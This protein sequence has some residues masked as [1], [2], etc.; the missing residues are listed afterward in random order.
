[1]TILF[2]HHTSD[3]YGASRSLLRLTSR[4]RAEGHKV[5]AILP[6]KGSLCDELDRVGVEVVLL[7]SLA[8][9]NR[10][11][12]GLAG[13]FSLLW[14]LPLSVL[15]IASLI[16]RRDV[17]LVHTN[18]AVILSSPI[19]ARLCGRP[20]VWHVRGFFTEFPG[21]WK[22]HRWIM[23]CLSDAVI[24]VSVAVSR[25]FGEPDGSGRVRVIHNGFPKQEFEGVSQARVS[26][27][28]AAFGLNGGP[29]AGVVGRIKL[30]RKGQE[31][32]I[33]AAARLAERLPKAKFL[34]IGSPFPGNEE[35]LAELERM[36]S[37]Y[38][39]KGRVIYTGDVADIKAAFAALDVTV[40]PTTLP[41]PFGGVVVE[42]M[43]MGRP[44]VA[45]A[46]E[47]A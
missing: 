47:E 41:E 38:G 25:Q 6:G 30:R 21:L 22:I 36:V 34:L 19:A 46:I 18:T 29:V 33:R 28:R 15:C 16:R 42:S 1:M 9:V 17:D 43:A 37:Q 11:S 13:L 10:A 12:F 35:H 31:V 3:L 23:R 20:H 39:L 27:F 26:A 2:A 44:V 40:L 32:F 5:I 14:K 45:T 8:P 7:P 4:L 24:A